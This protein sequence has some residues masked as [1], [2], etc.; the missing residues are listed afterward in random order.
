MFFVTAGEVTLQRTGLQGEAVVLQRTRIGF[1]SEA[2]LKVAGTTAMPW[3][4]LKPMSSNYQ[5]GK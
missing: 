1:V 3:P 2:S 4:S 5:S